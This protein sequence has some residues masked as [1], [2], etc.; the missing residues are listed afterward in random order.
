MADYRLYC[1][2]DRGTLNLADWIEADSDEEA[3]LKAREV[4]PDAHQCEVRLKN[5]LIAKINAAGR[6]EP[7]ELPRPFE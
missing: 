4:R 1:L 5:R 3:V 2:D 7:I 6:L